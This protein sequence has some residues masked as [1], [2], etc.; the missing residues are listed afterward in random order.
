[1]IAA[2]LL[3]VANAPP[4]PRA[5]APQT[6]A[7]PTSGVSPVPFDWSVLQPAPYVAAPALTPELSAFVA[8]EIASGRCSVAKPADGRYTLRVDVAVLVNA[9]GFVRRA[10]PHAIFC[11]TV[12]QYAAGLV[13]GFARGNLTAHP[14]APDIWYRAT[15][16]FDWRG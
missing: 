13:L 4:T 16:T 3:Q 14:G 6:S 5:V 11:P 7:P 1:M 15:I 12:E 10:V 9:A 8:G 2:L